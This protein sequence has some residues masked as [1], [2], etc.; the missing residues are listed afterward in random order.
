LS[1]PASLRLFCALRLRP[2][3]VHQLAEWQAAALPGRRI[4]PPENL[5]L[6]LVFLGATPSDALGQIADALEALAAGSGPI[7][8]RL[9]GYREVRHAGMLSFDDETGAAGALAEGLAGAL[10]ELGLLQ[11]RERRPWLPHLT[12]VRFA[13]PPRLR[14]EPPELGTVS[15]SDTA[16]Y[17]SVLRPDGARYEALEARP[18]GG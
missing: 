2:E 1:R 5:H 18:L 7:R 12:V 13:T 17:S 6:T 15:P 10:A 4:V 14:P 8:L 3:T 9:R 11:R 16:V